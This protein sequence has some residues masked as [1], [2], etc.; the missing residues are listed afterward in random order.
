MTSG[1]TPKVAGAH[2]DSEKYRHSYVTLLER[3]IMLFHVFYT[4][5]ALTP[6]WRGQE[7]GLSTQ[8][9]CLNVGYVMLVLSLKFYSVFGA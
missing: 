1:H 3:V 4:L 9:L 8:N 6:V 2:A 5:T 7:P